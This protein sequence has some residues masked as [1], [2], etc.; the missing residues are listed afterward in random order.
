MANTVTNLTTLKINYLTAE[1]YAAAI[2]GGQINENEL[3]MTPAVAGA[4]NV[5]IDADYDTGTKI[6]TITVD[7]TDY[8]LYVPISTAVS[9]SGLLNS[10]TTIGTVTINGTNY[11]IK[12][13]AVVD[14][15]SATGT[16]PVDGK[17]IARA[18]GTL[19]SSISATSNQA[20]SAI[21]ITDGKI[22]SSSKITIPSGRAA[23][24]GVDST[25]SASSTSTNLPTSAAVRSFV[26][27]KGYLT[28]YTETDPTVPA[29]AKAQSKPTYTA[30]EV[31]ALPDSTVIPTVVNT[32]SSTGTDAISGTGVAAALGTLDSSISATS[33]Q[34][35]SAITITNG[36]I[37]S[38]SK[39]SI[40]DST[41]DL[42]NDS[43]F[44]TLTDV[45]NAGYITESDIPEGAARSSATPLPDAGSGSAGTSNAFARGDHVH[46]VSGLTLVEGSGITLTESGSTLTIAA[47]ITDA[48][49]FKG[50]IGTGGTV[51]ALPNVYKAGWTYRVITAGT[52]AGKACEIGD[53]LIAI[54]DRS[55]GTAQN[56]EWT[57]AQTNITGATFTGTAKNVSVSGTPA[58]SVTITTADNTSG[59]Y[60]PKGTV[61]TPTFTGTSF[62]STGTFTPS[63]SVAVGTTTSTYTVSKASSGTATYTPAGTV[64]LTTT[65]KTIAVSPAS[66]GTVTYTPEGTI[67]FTNTDKDVSISY[68]PAG[69]VGLTNSTAS[70][71][72]S[73]GTGTATYTPQGTVGTPTIS[74]KTAGSTG[75][76]ATGLAA[77]APGATAPSNATTYYSYTNGNLSLYQLGYNT[78]T[79][80]TGDAVYQSSQ[81]SWTGTGTR[82]TG[83]VS[84]P[85]SA[86]F[87]G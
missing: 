25:I 52:Y 85:S 48:M 77:T 53:L 18:L 7:D 36:K 80:K 14:T 73:G 75:A 78:G 30:S 35:I 33:G 15:Y 49:V 72:V 43:N 84:V 29:W 67:A 21:T 62:N 64:N 41:S 32:Y 11:N 68:T 23:S 70:F 74:V 17:A 3:Y 6:A 1:Q 10:G 9:I 40:P 87:T 8:D 59:N 20:I 83:S 26:E 63:G 39:I 34:A 46:P 82:L 71:T 42:T 45:A 31:G 12:I 27:G 44:I 4:T 5:T 16:D 24:K 55:S 58:G 19:D 66:S 65:S 81:P 13:P 79:F 57:V 50:T 22:A 38:S 69:S 86:S 54:A 76:A 60:Q 61:S 28:S 51:T 37:A 56:S 47:D 2:A